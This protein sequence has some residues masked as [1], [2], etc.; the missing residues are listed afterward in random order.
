VKISKEAQVGLLGLVAGVILYIGFNFLKGIDFFSPTRHY[1]VVYNEVD[2]LT[3]SNPVLINGLT[4]GRVNAIKLLPGN[5]SIVVT[6]DVDKD[7]RLLDSTYAKL[8]TSDILGSKSIELIQAGGHRF[9]E[10]GDTLLSMKAVNITQALTER[11]LPILD[12]IDSTV[13]RV[14]HLLGGRLEKTIEM[15]LG[16]VEAASQD[17]KTLMSANKDNI[18][19]ISSNLASLTTSLKDTEKSVKPLIAKMNAIADSLNDMELKQAINKA[20]AGLKNVQDITARIEQ[21]HGNLGKLVND[22]S[23]YNNLNS[24][25]RDLDFLLL[26]FQG[27]PKKY[28]NFSLISIGNGEKKK[29][30]ESQK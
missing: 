24:S 15:T 7:V 11:A 3:V 26:D 19:I 17:L 4:I 9:L 23:L 2:G 16:N 21:G 20:N 10:N 13:T 27:N 22:S 18:S 5:K 8:T 14:N 29:K 28:V 6:L 12:N 1:Y 25:L 30:K